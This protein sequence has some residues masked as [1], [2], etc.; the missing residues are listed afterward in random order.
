MKNLWLFVKSRTFFKHL[1]IYLVVISLF[2]WLLFKWLDVHTGHGDTIEV[3]DYTNMKITDTH[4]FS[5]NLG[6]RDTII[7]SLFDAKKPPGVVISQDPEPKTLV[8]HNRTIYLYVTSYQPQRVQMP[9][10]IDASPRQAIQML[11]SYGL[12]MGKPFSKPGLKCVLQQLY[13]GKPIKAGDPIPKGSVIDLWIGKGEGD[14]VVGVP[15]LD[16][17]K[18]EEAYNELVGAQLELGAIV[19]LEC[20]TSSDSAS[21]RVYKQYPPKG[22]EV[23]SGSSVDIYLTLDAGKLPHDSVRHP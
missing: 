1:G 19:C 17:M 12:K 6:L 22:K 15:P 2:L 20:K 7:D 5:A 9:N 4:G 3:P 8:K 11:E 10:L 18:I 16:G 23:S 21:A 13:K 14:D